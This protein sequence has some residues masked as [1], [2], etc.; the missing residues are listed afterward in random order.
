MG[1]AQRART[2]A[3]AEGQTVEGHNPD[4]PTHCNVRFLSQTNWDA[5]VKK[6][7][8]LGLRPG[9]PVA[10]VAFSDRRYAIDRTGQFRRLPPAG[11]DRPQ[12]SSDS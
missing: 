8:Q 7:T 4:P 6:A 9:Q 11:E 3:K 12:A 2:R 10:N 1:Y 5:A